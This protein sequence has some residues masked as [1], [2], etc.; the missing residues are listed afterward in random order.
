[1]SSYELTFLL[2]PDLDKKTR[3]KVVKEVEKAIKEG[4]GSVVEKDDWGKKILAYEIEHYPE[5]HYYHLVFEG[6]GSLPKTLRDM[7]RL[8]EEV[9]RKL[10]VA[11]EARKN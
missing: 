2:K 3:N 1:M 4:K 6:P 5:A 9:M 11:K 10:I 7:L 8:K